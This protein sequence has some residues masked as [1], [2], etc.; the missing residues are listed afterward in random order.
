MQDIQ[1]VF[2]RMNA[3][4]KERKKITDICKET[5][6]NSKAYQNALE[7]LNDA[8]AKKQQIE[9]SLKADLRGELDQLDKIKTEM[10]TDK[11]I[12]TD[13]TLTKLMKGET[14][15]L[16]DEYDAKYEPVFSVKFKKT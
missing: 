4:K 13:I 16:T 2:Q 6:A 15:E 9:T 10:E 1:E 7:A 14:V 3:T 12:L 5:L 8:K 11:Q